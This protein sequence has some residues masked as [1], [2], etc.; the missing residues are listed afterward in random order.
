MH[1]D[2]HQGKVAF[3]TTTDGCVWLG[4]PL[5]QSD[6]RILLSSISFEGNDWK[7]YLA[8]VTLFNLSISLHFLSN[9]AV[10]NLTM[11]CL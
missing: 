4:V 2:S 8:I 6:F 9:V 10:V 5:D 7:L 11:T 1:G 3:K